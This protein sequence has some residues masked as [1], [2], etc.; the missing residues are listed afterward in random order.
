MNIGAIIAVLLI[1][2]IVISITI[3]ALQ[4]KKNK[5]A[6]EKT[7]SLT[8]K[9]ATGVACALLVA[10]ILIPGSFHT[11]DTGEVAV[12]KHLGEARNV[13]SAGTY[14]DFWLTESYNYYDAKVQ[15]AE[16]STA[17]YSKDAQTMDVL[18]TI[19]YQI[20]TSKTIEIANKYGSLNILGNRIQSVAT[21]KAK[22]EL[23]K[24]KAMDIIAN[25]AQMSPRVEDVIKNAI[26]DSYHVNVIAVVLTD[27]TFTDA[28]ESAVEQ[29][30]IAEQAKLKAEY[31]NQTKVAQA[32]AEAEAKLKAAQAEIEIAEAQAEAKLKQ[33]EY[34]I[35]IAEAKAQ[36]KLKE[37]GAEAEALRIKSLDVA[38]MLGFKIAV[39][40]NG[41]EY[42][43]FANSTQ[44]PEAINEYLKYLEYMA[45]WDGK[46]PEVLTG[47]GDFSMILPSN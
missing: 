29:K 40:A 19:Q 7:F 31:E 20:D 5:K 25:R 2:G 46:L 41:N 1:I 17:A 14:F 4:S 27:I 28:F 34:E 33:A 22:S 16:I 26:G 44:D 35:Q 18:M 8:S 39:D 24:D 42:I 43:D 37:I 10:L 45:K 32:E 13:R 21:E 11:V 47:D 3:I 23:S 15:N 6:K 36:A 38:R 12:V 9:I 30:M